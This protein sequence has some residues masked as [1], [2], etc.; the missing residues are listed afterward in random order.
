MRYC[1]YSFLKIR[2]VFHK[3]LQI[4][5]I[6]TIVTSF[7]THTIN[8][9]STNFVIAR[10]TFS[11]IFGLVSLFLFFVILVRNSN[12]I[13]GVLQS[14][15]PS[16]ILVVGLACSIFLSLNL[17]SS[18]AE[19]II[20][21][22]LVLLFGAFC[23]SFKNSLVSVFF[24]LLMYTT[25]ITATV[26]LYDLLA[27]NFNFP[28]I[29]KAST[30]NMGV[31][32]FRYF[33]QAANYMFTMLSILIPLK[34]SNFFFSL[35]SFQKKFLNPTIILG[36]LFLFTTGRISIIVSFALA[37][38]LHLLFYRNKKAMRHSFIL[39]G[40][41]LV[42][43]IWVHFYLPE[44]SER[45]VYRIESRLTNRLV[46]T[47]EAEFISENFKGAF[48]AFKDQPLTGSGLGAF[49]NNYSRFEI[50]GTY[51]KM[52]GETG[53]VGT[54]SYLFFILSFMFLFKPVLLKNKIINRNF[55]KHFLPFL[56]ANLVSWSY[57]HHLRKKE[58]WILYA[59]LF[60]AYSNF[61]AQKN[62]PQSHEKEVN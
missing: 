54:I 22:Y 27:N 38:F 8:I 13:L 58:F 43:I 28:V 48:R 31:S 36:I 16:L 2:H 62:I 32:G 25:F 50:H 20:V 37:V 40:F 60:I 44:V 59:V 35:S 51:L 21:L 5:L 7:V 3:L 11:D 6:G 23:Y 61:S 57:N 41:F 19:V 26:G 39:G 33:G 56:I 53:I 15:K 10:M 46:G 17:K 12:E 49:V 24:P 4:A 14:L 34:Y 47:P 18:I 9:D 30:K 42:T 29:F 55:L 52:I 45:I 1:Q